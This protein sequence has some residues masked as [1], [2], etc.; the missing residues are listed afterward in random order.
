MVASLVVL[1]FAA[2]AN[3]LTMNTP[4]GPMNECENFQLTWLDAPGAT[5][6]S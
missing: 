2:A 3:A 6:I 5:Q 4:T 1:A